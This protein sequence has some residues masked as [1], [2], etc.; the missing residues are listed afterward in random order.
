MAAPAGYRS[1]GMGLHTLSAESASAPQVK[2]TTVGWPVTCAISS[3]RP[4]L[5]SMQMCPVCFS[6]H[7]QVLLI[8]MSFSFEIF[9]YL[10]LQTCHGSQPFVRQRAKTV[11]ASPYEKGKIIFI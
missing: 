3:R 10:V 7:W 2:Q 11:G 8:S 1:S 4:A 6:P 9:L 5:F